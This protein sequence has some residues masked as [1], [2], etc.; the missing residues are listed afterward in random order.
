MILV[1]IRIA[2]ILVTTCIDAQEYT[3]NNHNKTQMQQIYTCM[4]PHIYRTNWLYSGIIACKFA[5][6]RPMQQYF[7]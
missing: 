2:K 5:T 3:F 6:I 1:S 4:P 7:V